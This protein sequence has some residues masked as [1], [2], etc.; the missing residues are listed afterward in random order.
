MAGGIEVGRD[1]DASNF[2]ICTINGTSAVS[3][4]VLDSLM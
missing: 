1:G 3:I 4:S 2:T